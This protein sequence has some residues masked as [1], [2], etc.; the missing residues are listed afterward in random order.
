MLAAGADAGSGRL[1]DRKTV[2]G[3]EGSDEAAGA[4]RGAASGTGIQQR[5]RA[6]G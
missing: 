1:G 6:K 2:A 3:G 4:A 5:S